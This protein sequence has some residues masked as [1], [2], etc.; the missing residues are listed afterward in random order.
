MIEP[1]LLSELSPEALARIMARSR[2]DVEPVKR[3]VA[4]IVE[5]VAERGDEAVIEYTARF[6]GAELTPDELRVAEDEFAEARKLVP[7]RTLKALQRAALR[8]GEFHQR[9][10][11]QGAMFEL[12][13]GITVGYSYKPISNVGIYAPGGRAAYPSTVL[14]AAIPAKIAGVK[15]IAM[16]TPPSPEGKANPHA[17]M[18]AMLAG[19]DEVY[20]V[21]G[22]QA[23][24]AMAFGTQTI[25]KVDKIVGP[26]NIYVTAAKLLVSGQVEIDFPAGPSEILIVADE[27]ADPE[28]VAWDMLSQAE[29]D[30]D[31]A[32]VLVT[33]NMRLAEAVAERLAELVERSE[34]ASMIERSLE[35]NGAIIVVSSLREAIAL[36]NEYAPEHLM[37]LTKQWKQILPLIENAGAIFVGPN[38][39]V[40][41]GDYCTGPNHVL[42]TGGRAKASSGLSVMDFMKMTTVQILDSRGLRSLAPIAM[43]LARAEGLP[44]H[45][46]AVKA[47]F[48]R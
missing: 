9:Q 37:L 30:P 10:L 18:A 31:A 35:R 20:K 13:D 15:R 45:F 41:I 11:P 40:A 42:P 21:G 39:P 2:I 44:G 47:R 17:L 6:D 32:A 33:T 26:G 22:P 27:G 5:D 12:G 25:P 46:E 38:S 24:A 28:L 4:R 36:A 8:I 3:H 23:I 14:M 19:V 16:C 34:R 1:K 43:E 48:K 29:H 7:E